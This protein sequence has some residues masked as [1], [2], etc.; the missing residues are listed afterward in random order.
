MGWNGSGS[1]ERTNGTNTGDD[2]WEQDK[3]AGVKITTA[4][5]DTHDQDLADGIENC[6]AKDGQNAM[7][8]NLNMGGKVLINYGSDNDTV[9]SITSGTYTPI[10]DDPADWTINSASGRY[11]KIGNLV[12][13]F[14]AINATRTASIVSNKQLRI[15]DLPYTAN[16][17]GVANFSV[18]TGILTD[19]IIGSV[20]N[21]TT[22]IRVSQAAT[23][24]L[25]PVVHDQVD[26]DSLTTIVLAYTATYTTA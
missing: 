17:S 20:A 23:V 8:A 19:G 26:I 11:V 1:F 21:G 15:N 7:T 13:V 2:V 14:G 12:T 10:L 5:H 4:R 3:D 9:P 18:Y 25:P 16:A 24:D 6:L 22:E